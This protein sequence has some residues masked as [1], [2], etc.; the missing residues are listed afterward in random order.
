[1]FPSQGLNT[2]P[3]MNPPINPEWQTYKC[4]VQKHRAQER[5][6]N[7]HRHQQGLIAAKQAAAMLKNQFGAIEVYL[8]GSL[9]TPEAVHASSDLDLGARGLSV[10]R[11]CE[12]VGAL[13]CEL[14]EF[15]VDVVR[16]ESAQ[17]SLYDKI[18]TEGV[19][20]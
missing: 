18:L 3:P 12:A 11:Y 10:K 4:H 7:H 8:L 19:L 2:M 6:H 17:P 9:L 1:L 15:S 20:L 16:L 13:L 5:R 14:Q